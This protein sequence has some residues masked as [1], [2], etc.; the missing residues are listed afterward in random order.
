M[1]E[2][3]VRLVHE[4][5]N[6]TTG[7][8]AAVMVMTIVHFNTRKRKSCPFPKDILQRGKKLIVSYDIEL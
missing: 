4:M 6:D 1:K 2:K 7:E 8:V 3:V 5:R